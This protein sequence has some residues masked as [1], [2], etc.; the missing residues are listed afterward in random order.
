MGK[1]NYTLIVNLI[2]V[3]TTSVIFGQNFKLPSANHLEKKYNTINQKSTSI[4]SD[5]IWLNLQN[6]QGAFSQILIGFIDGATNYIDRD[7][8][9]VRFFGSN[10]VAFYS[11]CEE[12]KLA[13]QGR[14]LRK[15]YEII[16]LGIYST[17]STKM[18]LQIK[19][20]ELQGQLNNSDIEIILEDKLLNI[21]HDLKDSSYSFELQNNGN[22]DDRFNLIVSNSN[23]LGLNDY[24]LND[25]LIVTHSENRLNVQTE[26]N[27]SISS[28]RAFDN[29]GRTL[30][31]LRPNGNFFSI[32]T[33]NIKNGTVLFIN[34]KLINNQTLYKKVLLIQ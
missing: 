33:S 26:D 1:I 22:F 24:K 6:D 15:D 7:Y 28:F 13:I 11:I 32:N 9:G 19:I 31:N 3:L 23:T 18:D 21:K 30:I 34:V 25:N 20:D 12:I 5:K 8:D 17:V 27:V 29:L 16:P 14:E 2:L 10:P 4:Q